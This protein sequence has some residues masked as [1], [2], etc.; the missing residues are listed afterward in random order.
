[1]WRQPCT[2]D[3]ATFTN[4]TIANMPS[5]AHCFLVLVVVAMCG[6]PPAAA[7]LTL[8]RYDS[9][10]GIYYYTYNYPSVDHD[11]RPITLSALMC[12]PR[13]TNPSADGGNDGGECFNNVVI[14]CHATIT[15]NKECPSS[16]LDDVGLVN[17][18]AVMT[19]YASA[20]GGAWSKPVDDPT[21]RNIV[22][23]PDYQGYGVSKQS[24]HPYLNQELTAKQVL[25]AT[26][27][28]L[29]QLRAGAFAADDSQTRAL[30]T[31]AT[32]GMRH[33]WGTIAIGV[34]Q[35][36]A[37]ALATQRYAEQNQLDTELRLR[38][39]I[40]A[41]GPYDPIA[42][43][44]FYTSEHSY[45]QKDIVTM[46]VAVAML[47][48]GLLECD[49]LMAG[50]RLEDYFSPEFIQTGIFQW[51]DNKSN[52]ELEKTASEITR[53]L[54]RLCRDGGNGLTTSQCRQLFPDYG[55]SLIRG[56]HAYGDLRRMLTDDAYHYL[57]NADS[58][59]STP[60]PGSAMHDLHLALMRNTITTD[61]MPAHP[62]ALFHSTHDTVVP[63]DNF[64]SAHRAF[65]EG[66]TLHV[67]TTSTSDHV[68]A[69]REFLV[70]LTGTSPAERF[71]KL[72]C[73]HHGS[74][75]VS[76]IHIDSPHG[77][78]DGIVYDLKGRVL[79]GVP[80]HEP[81]IRNR[82]IVLP[83]GR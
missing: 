37:V 28:G 35:G 74:D 32:H 33:D 80:Q 68:D 59:S 65:G 16:R 23:M 64:E 27:Y 30:A 70:N 72:L 55:H 18:I 62:V 58:L 17:D 9:L 57:S 10:A 45:H 69:C 36:A 41:D 56:Y 20:R 83:S 11:G 3:A 51:I 12:L 49:P 26:A 7:Q 52:P 76:D 14:A 2:G 63:F 39:S 60:E 81:Y 19:G 77:A 22:I 8:Q 40:C 47:V 4:S 43:L 79:P 66:C 1:M 73:N 82:R 31:S 78:A 44:R 42:T 61:W 15:S 24:V 53:A 21:C 67:D 5:I 29:E 34:S 13:I 38:G 25:D 71:I 54:Y 6:M 46:P 75:A 50:H 48:K